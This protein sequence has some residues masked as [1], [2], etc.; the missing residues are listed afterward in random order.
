MNPAAILALL[1]DL[2]V[3]NAQLRADL[4][5]ALAVRDGAAEPDQESRP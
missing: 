4:E 5:K 1:S 2:Y 3:Q